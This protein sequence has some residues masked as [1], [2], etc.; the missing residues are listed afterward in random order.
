M[1]HDLCFSFAAAHAAFFPF[2]GLSVSVAPGWIGAPPRPAFQ[3]PPALRRSSSKSHIYRRSI[4]RS[5]CSTRAPA[6]CTPTPSP[7]PNLGTGKVG[8][9]FY[10]PPCL[11]DRQQADKRSFHTKSHLQAHIVPESIIYFQKYGT[12]VLFLFAVLF[13]GTLQHIPLIY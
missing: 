9:V 13:T 3:K 5:R 10:S 1:I 6:R 4:F 2:P 7:V 11:P 12:N 8:A